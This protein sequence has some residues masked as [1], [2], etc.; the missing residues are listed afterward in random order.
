MKKSKKVM[1]LVVDGFDPK[2]LL[3]MLGAAHK[4]RPQESDSMAIDLAGKRC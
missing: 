4:A 1:V 2:I 3:P